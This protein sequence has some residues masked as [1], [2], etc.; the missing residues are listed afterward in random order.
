MMRI[1]RYEIERELGRGGMAVVYLAND[2]YIKRQVAVKVLPHQFT[3]EERFRERFQQEAQMIA[4]LEHSAIVPIH[5]F[6]EYDHQPFLV[7]RYMPGGSL[8]ERIT[9]PMPLAGISRILT[10]LAPALDKAHSRGFIHRDLKPGNVLFDEDNQAYLADFGIARMAEASHTMTIAGTPA[11]MSPEQVKGDQKLD[12]RS[13]IYALGVMLFEMLAGQPPYEADTPTKLMLKHI[14]E[15][16]PIILDLIPDL[17][18]DCQAFIEQVMA[19]DR[20]NRPSTATALAGSFA[21]L[22]SNMEPEETQYAGSQETVLDS[23]IDLRGPELE[24]MA[25]SEDSS[26]AVQ[27][28]VEGESWPSETDLLPTSQGLSIKEAEKPAPLHEKELEIFSRT[29]PAEL[30][31]YDSMPEAEKELEKPSFSLPWRTITWG[32]G[33]IA[34]VFLGI[35]LI[36]SFGSDIIPTNSS[37]ESVSEFISEKWDSE[38]EVTGLGYGSSQWIVVMDQGE[39]DQ[40][41]SWRLDGE[42][43]KAFIEEKWAAGYE[44]TSL[45]YGNGQWAVMMSQSDTDR[46]QTWRLDGEF[47]KTF[48]EEKWADGYQVTNLAYGGGQWA[49]MMSK[50][51]WRQTWRVDGDFPQTFIE[52]K[53]EE[54]Y[55]VTN[56]AYG[57]GQW[58]VIMSQSGADHQQTWRKDSD[59]PSSFINEKWAEGYELADLAY[60]GGQWAVMMSKSNQYQ[61]QIWSAFKE[62]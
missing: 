27:E 8:R 40:R 57:D 34:F 39:V 42:F 61:R 51:D 46:Q 19:K 5:D 1:G 62:W 21:R 35:I 37:G 13:D 38:Y 41:Q 59:F 28:K 7:M 23:S 29:R 4:A 50:G 3:F 44:V 58:A 36:R 6:G 15:P 48:I 22:A 20:D 31:R 52:G 9:G 47:P 16:V 12:G 53:W 11:Y 45:A 60:G 54:G 17:P 55:E 10:R 14:L 24:E 2:P 33:I 26:S 49:V 56:L 18:S 43:P 30:I 32:A 25:V